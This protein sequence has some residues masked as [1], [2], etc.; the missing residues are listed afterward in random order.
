MWVGETKPGIGGAQLPGQ[1]RQHFSVFPPGDGKPLPAWVAFDKRV[2]AFEGYF[3]ETEIN[4]NKE[5]I[6]VRPVKVYFYLEDD[7]VQVNEPLVEN[8]GL[9]QGVLIRR[10]RIPIPEQDEKFYTADFFNI[11]SE[12]QLYGRRFVLT[13]CDK[14]TFN[15]LT[16]MGVKVGQSVQI[17]QDQSTAKR[18]AQLNLMKAQRPYERIDTFG[19]FLEHDRE[20]LCFNGYWDDTDTKFGDVHHMVLHYFLADDTVEVRELY[21]P[22]AGRDAVPVF[23]HRGKLPRDAPVAVFA[24]GTK[25]PRTVLNVCRT[26]HLLDSLKTGAV[27]EV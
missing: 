1:R 21:K 10:H 5:E 14:F 12:L 8:S 16:K 24:P 25:T 15:F 11:G 9:A 2:L 22:N 18:I 17:P 26:H 3:E 13:D 7:T 27:S 19:Q 23:L 6:R 4:K 20:V